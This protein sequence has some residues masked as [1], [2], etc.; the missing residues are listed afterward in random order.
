MLIEFEERL[1]A[2]NDEA[3]R[4]VAWSGEQWVQTGGSFPRKAWLEGQTISAEEAGRRFPD[5]DL[6]SVPDLS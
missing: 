1:I 2:T 3:T 6:G 5:A 4:A